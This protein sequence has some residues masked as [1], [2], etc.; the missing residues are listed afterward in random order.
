MAVLTRLDRL[1]PRI[2]GIETEYGIVAV[3]AKGSRVVDAD[4][5]GHEMFAQIQHRF[6][7]SSVFL[8]NGGRLYLDVG[9]HPEYATAECCELDDV[10]AQDRAGAEI[11]RDM[12]VQA[13]KR[14]SEKTATPTKVHL[15]KNN[16]DSAGN[17]C[18]C[19][20]N[21]LLYRTGKFRE[22]ADAL[23]VFLVTRQVFL[24]AGA[25]LRIQGKTRFCL[26]QRAFQIDDT[27]SGATTTTRPLVNT[28]DEPHA[29]KN[30][31]RRLHVI[32]GD[33]NV[34]EIPTRFKI[35]TMNLLLGAIEAG[36]D[37]S[38]LA[39]AQPV[40]ALREITLSLPH[41]GKPI[42][43]A[44]G[45]FY[46]ALQLQTEF[47]NRLEQIYDVADL[48]PEYKEIFHDWRSW[49][50]ILT[51]G[52]YAKLNGVL[53]WPTK[54]VLLE[55]WR[56]RH[57]LSWEDSKLARLDLAY[58]DL[59]SGLGLEERGLARRLSDVRAV[60][61][62]KTVPPTNTRAAL[63]GEFIR[64]ATAKGCDF[65]AD[66]SHLRLLG[67]RPEAVT[68]PDPFAVRSEAVA[69]LLAIMEAV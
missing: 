28:R 15:L 69:K 24:G 17:S 8:G 1:K 68:L 29:D 3:D 12:A 55:L 56:T 7:A 26:S 54:L 16:L 53:D 9:S 35:G 23:V 41:E 43:L 5:V 37:F 30:R 31:Y 4:T 47:C 57:Q 66:W 62:A 20:E 44:D 60:E 18:G 6:R 2:F 52:N 65:Q 46:T 58:H 10:L 13:G 36:G 61:R 50:E 33:S 40:S 32:V 45:R 11:L 51:T 49:I 63:R 14:L 64:A 39:L 48:P 19:H 38:D 21:Y 42:E 25:L 59:V 27:V 67:D 34:L 22:L